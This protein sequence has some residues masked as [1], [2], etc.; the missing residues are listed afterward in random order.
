MHA[1]NG[2]QSLPKPILA[3]SKACQNR[4][5]GRRKYSQ[6]APQTSQ[7]F[8]RRPKTRPRAPKRRPRAPK[9]PPK[10]RPRDSLT[11]QKPA[12]RA[13][14]PILNAILM[15]SLVRKAPGP[16]LYGFLARA[17]SLRHGQNLDLCRSCQCFVRVGV[18]AWCEPAVA[19]N[20]RKIYVLERQNPPGVLPGPSK[21]ESKASQEAGTPA[22]SNDKRSKE[23][24]SPP[25]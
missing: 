14:R 25:L 11:L 18:Y 12:R 23:C 24:K 6:E 15:G 9:G 2:F 4:G 3:P 10:R 16:I 20:P 22:R 5:P 19:Q 13:R 17:Q 21:I 1:K 7:E 8:P